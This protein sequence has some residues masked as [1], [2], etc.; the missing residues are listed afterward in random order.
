M[1]EFIFFKKDYQ[2]KRG[3]LAVA[4]GRLVALVVVVA[5][6]FSPPAWRALACGAR[7]PSC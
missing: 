1:N 6:I 4:V 7:C 2:V 3:D 5:L